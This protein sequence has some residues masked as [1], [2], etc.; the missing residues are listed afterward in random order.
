M[1]TTTDDRTRGHDETT[2][3]HESAD[4]TEEGR[5]VRHVGGRPWVAP[6]AIIA[7]VTLLL[8][9]VL[10]VFAWPAGSPK[11]R[12]LPIAVA[13]PQQATA[14]M[15]QQL[16]AAG[17]GAF[18]VLTVPD[19]DAA[20]A[21]VEDREAYAALVAGPQPELLTAPAASPV[22]AQMLTSQLTESATAAG[23]QAPT[24][25]EVVPLP[26]GDPRGAVFASSA[27]PLVMAGSSPGRL[28]P[29]SSAGA[30]PRR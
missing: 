24:V 7:G 17:E 13:G 23:G 28:S 3:H 6:L 22:V 1:T 29:S 2:D 25:T 14:A 20:V 30:G 9:L 21:A 5:H 26:E 16:S 4:A 18:A 15:S 10:T 8:T 12:D 11:P 27:L 19:R